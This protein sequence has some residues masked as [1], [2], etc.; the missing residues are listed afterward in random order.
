MRLKLDEN[1]GRRLASLLQ[2]DGHDVETVPGEGL[3]GSRDT[4]VYAAC[5]T[6]GRT[7]VTLDLD[8]SNP[9]RFPPED[10]EGILV[11]R[12]RRATLSAIEATLVSVMPQ[13]KSRSLKGLLWVVEPGRIRVYD[14]HDEGH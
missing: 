12:P 4:T 5:Q 10:T 1:F 8:F 7:L 13:L 6:E 14:P 9:F 2:T 11:I 3:S